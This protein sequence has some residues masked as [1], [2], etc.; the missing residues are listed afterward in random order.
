MVILDT[1]EK[2][3]KA[4]CDHASHT[5]GGRLGLNHAHMCVSK[6]EGNGLFFGFK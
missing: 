2:Y 6:S 3:L 5:R 4:M 1:I